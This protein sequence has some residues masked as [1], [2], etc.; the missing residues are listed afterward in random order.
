ME[1]YSYLERQINYYET[2]KMAVVHHSNYAR[3]LEECR[4]ELM[5]HFGIPLEYFEEIGYMI[6]VVEL[7]EKFIESARFGETVKIVPLLAKVTPVKFEFHYKIY[8]DEMTRVIH[9]A[10]TLH[11]FI[12]SEYKPVSMKRENPELYNKLLDIQK[13]QGE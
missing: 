11:C 3:F 4:I 2:D 9:E 7:H 13:I 5:K 10:S 12:D 1:K 8:N 6:P